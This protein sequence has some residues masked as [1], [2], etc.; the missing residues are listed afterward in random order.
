[1]VKELE[2][3]SQGQVRLAFNTGM[4]LG[5]AR[6]TTMEYAIKIAASV[7]SR[8][9]QDA[10]PFRMWPA[11]ASQNGAPSRVR[12]ILEH[13]ARLEEGPSNAFDT[14]LRQ[15]NLDGVAI[16]VLSAGDDESLRLVAHRRLP[17]TVVLMEG[18]GADEDPRAA[19]RLAGSGVE[20]V[21]CRPG[22]LPATLAAL[23]N[24]LST[25]GRSHRGGIGQS[26]SHAAARWARVPARR[27]P[28]DGDVGGHAR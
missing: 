27:A 10:R 18:F 3:V 24:T 19:A 26:S 28:F 16:L 21:P 17:A 1:M 4:N 14:M 11:P 2:Q 8:C 6:D 7:A 13:L 12:D 20:V 25:G 22:E 23:S 15:A 9:F 5:E